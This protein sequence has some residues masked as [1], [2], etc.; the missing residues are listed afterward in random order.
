MSNSRV[1]EFSVFKIERFAFIS[2]DFMKKQKSRTT[3]VSKTD[4]S[5]NFR[6]NRRFAF[7][8]RDFLKKK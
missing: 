4:F 1:S 5:E 7:T 6:K 8:E 3:K 2:P